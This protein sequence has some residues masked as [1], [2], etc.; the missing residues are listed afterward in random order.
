MALAERFPEAT[1]TGFDYVSEM[2]ES[3]REQAQRLELDRVRFE[4]GDLLELEQAAH[5]AGPW[6]AVFT[7]R[8]L[9]N[10]LDADLQAAAI[11]GLAGL[12]RPGGTL[13]VLEN[14]ASTYARQNELRTLAGLPLREPAAH[15]RFVD[16]DVLAPGR[17]GSEVELAEVDD[18][19]SLHDLVLYVLVPMIAD[20]EVVYD[21]PLVEAA[22]KLSLAGAGRMLDLAPLGQNRLLRFKKRS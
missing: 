22:T 14:F 21:H 5:L 7:D 8:C 20:G 16:D 15:N 13:I 10:L 3:A 9:I 1:F 11:E 4:V 2:V 18:F 17:F 19:G 12:V 6:D